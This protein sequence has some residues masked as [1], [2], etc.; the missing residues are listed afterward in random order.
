MKSKACI[1][2]RSTRTLN[3]NN[4]CDRCEAAHRNSVQHVVRLVVRPKKGRKS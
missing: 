4:R 2:C 3:I 1:G